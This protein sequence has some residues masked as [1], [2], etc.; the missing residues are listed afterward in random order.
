[1]IVKA[2]T[3]P[4]LREEDAEWPRWDLNPQPPDYESD[5]LPVELQDQIPNPV[6]HRAR[7]A[8]CI[9]QMPDSPKD[10]G[11]ARSSTYGHTNIR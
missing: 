8:I 2:G 6:T 7:D 1:M 4:G 5:A 3:Q 10:D 11:G 9:R